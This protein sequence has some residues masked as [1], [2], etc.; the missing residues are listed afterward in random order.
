MRRGRHRLLTDSQCTELWR[1]YK[2]G[3]SIL[4]IARTLGRDDAAV[5]R[6]LQATGGIVP[7]IRHRSA[8]VLSLAEREEIS[9]GIAAGRNDPRDRH[10]TAP[11]TFHGK[12]RGPPT[13]RPKALSCC[14]G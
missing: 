4:G 14:R 11:G 7:A 5:S 2:A 8:R 6:V 12:P 10:G 13:W 9:R 3:E 1:M